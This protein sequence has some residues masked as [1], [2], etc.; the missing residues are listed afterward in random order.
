MIT[1]AKFE[2][3]FF[4]ELYRI[5]KFKGTQWVTEDGIIYSSEASAQSHCERKRKAASFN[6]EKIHTLRYT[7]VDFTTFPFGTD[8][9]KN[10][11]TINAMFDKME[12]QKRESE[13]NYQTEV[14]VNTSMT[15]DEIMREMQER[16]GGKVAE[17]AKATDDESLTILDVAYPVS[18][19]KDALR[20]T[21]APKLHHASGVAKV[22]ETVEALS[23]EDKAILVAE[24]NK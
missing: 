22:T 5:L 12:A 10:V 20:A 2:Q 15:D 4:M 13:R 8:Y 1:L 3:K 14:V 11:K 18:A 7:R 21:V 9:H 6:S 19:V 16:E 17:P 24:L 23:D